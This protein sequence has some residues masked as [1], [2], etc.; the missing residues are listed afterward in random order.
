MEFWMA[1]GSVPPI[2]DRAKHDDAPYAQMAQRGEL[3]LYEGR[4]VRLDA[5]LADVQNDL[6]GSKVRAAA[7]DSYKDSEAKDHLDRAA[8]RWPIEFRRIG[9]GK[10]GGA[11]RESVSAACPASQTRD[12]PELGARHGDLEIDTAQ[13]R[14]WKSRSRPG[15]QPRGASIS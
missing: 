14:K 3:K 8:V 4:V 12:A 9:A 13:G 6:A 7:A 10:S 2:S 15:D 11:G 5:F 1:Y